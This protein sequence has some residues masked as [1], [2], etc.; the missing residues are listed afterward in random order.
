M[1]IKQEFVISVASL[2]HVKNNTIQKTQCTHMDTDK[3]LMQII[4]SVI[5]AKEREKN[6]I[7]DL[8]MEKDNLE[9]IRE[10][11]SALR[12]E[13]KEEISMKY[14]LIINDLKAKI[15]TLEAQQ[16]STRS[17]T[18]LTLKTEDDLPVDTFQFKINK[19]ESIKE[20]SDDV[21]EFLK[22]NP[23]F[24]KVT[25]NLEYKTYTDKIRARLGTENLDN[26]SDSNYS[27]VFGSKF[28]ETARAKLQ[29]YLDGGR[30]EIIS[31]DDEIDQRMA[32]A[33]R[34]KMGI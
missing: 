23:L 32:S 12:D 15:K 25:R 6:C 9:R 7:R 26:S 17:N 34:D 14:D 5:R 18:D 1:N 8:D 30:D 10:W 24:S 21:P 29:E 2:P 27:S 16:E 4:T 13:I 33:M 3:E 20:T 22:S 19:A 28:E 11:S 31:E